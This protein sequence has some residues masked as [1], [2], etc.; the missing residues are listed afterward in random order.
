MSALCLEENIDILPLDWIWRQTVI[1][2]CVD[3][4]YVAT[5]AWC[6][7]P[8]CLQHCTYD[9]HT[10]SYTGEQRYSHTVVTGLCEVMFM[11]EGNECI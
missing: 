7:Q 3:S 2:K 9:T 1:I 4:R 11:G 6:D 8:G 5:V 10:H